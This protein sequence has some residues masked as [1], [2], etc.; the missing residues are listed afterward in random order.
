MN[1]YET[2]LIRL[3]K[4]GNNS[5]CTSSVTSSTLT[6]LYTENTPYS[7]NAKERSPNTRHSRFHDKE[8]EGEKGF[9]YNFVL[10]FSFFNIFFHKF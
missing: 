1:H 8:C 7:G 5:C 2:A 10:Y 6:Y 4:H 3:D 9:C